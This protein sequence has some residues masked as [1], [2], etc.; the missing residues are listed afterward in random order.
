M[1]VNDFNHLMTKHNKNTLIL[2]STVTLLIISCAKDPQIDLNP[3]P[4]IVF[5]KSSVK[6]GEP[7][8]ATSS[9]GP[10]GTTVQWTTGTNGQVWSSVNSDTATF[11]FTSAGT[12]E[13]KAVFI[14]GSNITGYDSSSTTI[15]VIDSLFT[16]TSTLHCNVIIQKTLSPDDQVSLTPISFSDTGLIFVAHTKNSYDHSPILDCGGNLPPTGGSFECDFNST[17][18]FPCLG[19]PLP[20]PAVGIV[21]FTSVT[22]GTFPLI[23]KL[24]GTTFSG[25]LTIT[26]TQATITWSYSSGVTI[27]PLT[28]QK[29]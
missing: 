4:A 5:S 7:L 21:S 28:I 16:D 10:A 13:V 25:G 17:L 20:A 22:S 19:S 6:I 12:Y 15:T 1:M 24:N 18:L 2:I 14:S 26:N 27:S 23:F 8:Y 9:G 11:L 29:Q 3:K